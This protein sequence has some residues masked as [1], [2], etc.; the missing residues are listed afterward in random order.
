MSLLPRIGWR[1]VVGW[2]MSGIAIAF[3]TLDGALKVVAIPAVVEASNE[4]G[5][6]ADLVPLLGVILLASTALYAT[7]ATALFGAILITGFLGGA[8]SVHVRQHA[9]LLSHVLF[10]VYIGVLV[11]GGL[12]LR[13][14]RLRALLP[15]RTSERA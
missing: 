2:V 15:F 9:P 10:G 14:P 6:S 11:W 5:F 12:Y 1:R 13:D 3:L 7:P 8:V 4:I